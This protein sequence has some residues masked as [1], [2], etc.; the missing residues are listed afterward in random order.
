MPR[1]RDSRNRARPGK[2]EAR[3]SGALIYC[4][5]CAYPLAGL[6]DSR[7]PECG[8]PFDLADPRS[9]ST[10]DLRTRSRRLWIRRGIALLAV[11]GT[12]A[13]IAPRG[14]RKTTITIACTDCGTAHRIARSDLIPPRWLSEIGY[15]GIT[16]AAQPIQLTAANQATFLPFPVASWAPQAQPAACTHRWSQIRV[17]GITALACGC[18]PQFDVALNDQAASPQRLPLLVQQAADPAA[19]LKVHCLPRI[20]AS[21][22]VSSAPSP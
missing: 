20:S 19:T 10:R 17:S 21:S 3:V 11:I 8:T 13:V 16:H 18:W 12:V 2:I 4:R 9:V 5:K 22:P 14:I 15:P 6:S 7:C 1:R